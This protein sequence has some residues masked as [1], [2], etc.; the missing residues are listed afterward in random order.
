MLWRA[1]PMAVFLSQFNLQGNTASGVEAW[2]NRCACFNAILTPV[3][4]SADCPSKAAQC[5]R[6]DNQ[7]GLWTPDT[8]KTVYCSNTNDAH[9]SGE[10]PAACPFSQTCQW[11]PGLRRPGERPYP[12]TTAQSTALYAVE[13]TF[14]SK[15]KSPAQAD[16]KTNL[17]DKRVGCGE[18]SDATVCGDPDFATYKPEIG[19]YDA[20][21]L[22][23]PPMYACASW[24]KAGFPPDEEASTPLWYASV[25][26]H[27]KKLG[28]LPG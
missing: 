13:H 2:E 21:G 7:L 3:P 24:W 6:V 26:R 12:Q 19:A 23:W 22:L 20:G 28:A 25:R 9:G 16:G 15:H 14:G 11:I 1:T 10:S 8:W 5:G 18:Y 27:A 4:M 17:A